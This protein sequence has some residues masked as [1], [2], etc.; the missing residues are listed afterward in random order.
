MVENDKERDKE[1]ENYYKGKMRTLQFSQ[2]Q[3]QP[4]IQNFREISVNKQTE[5]K[6]HLFVYLNHT[7]INIST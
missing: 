7:C 5:I 4:A 3:A 1:G 2:L 6:H